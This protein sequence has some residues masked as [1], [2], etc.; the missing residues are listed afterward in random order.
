MPWVDKEKCTGCETCVEQCPVGAIFMTDSIAM[1]DME[2]CI[3]C[4]VCHNICPQDAIRHDS[5]KV[6]ENIDANVEKTKKSM[7][8]CVKYLGNVEEKDKC[9][10][11][12]LG[13]FR[14]EKEI[15]EKTIERLEKLKNV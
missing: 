11:R 3:R 2:K 9:L 10:K 8:L 4:G 1:I 7:G 13:H 6:Q 12:M 15:A 14:H 5:E